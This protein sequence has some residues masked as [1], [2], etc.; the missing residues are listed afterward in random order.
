MK[1][2][3][4]MLCVV[5]TLIMCFSV[6][7]IT[8]LGI[9]VEAASTISDSEITAIVENY[10]SIV[11]SNRYWNAGYSTQELISQVNR[12]DYTTATTFAQCPKWNSSG[13]HVRAN[14]CTSNV[15]TGVS[16]GL[17]QCWGFGDYMEYVIFK[18]INGSDWTKEYS[19]DSNFKF[20]PGDLIHSTKNSSSQHIMV[21]YKV[22]GSHVY[23]IEANY[24]ARCKINTR[25]LVDPHSYVNA[26]SSYVMVPPSSLRIEGHSHSYTTN[27]E[28]AHPHKYYESCSCGDWHYTGTTN[29]SYTY[30]NESA[31]PHKEY[32]TCWCGQ[33]SYTGGVG[34]A[35]SCESCWDIQF[36]SSHST[37]SLSASSNE[38][39]T[40]SIGLSGSVYPSGGK[41]DYEFDDSVISVTQID[42]RTYTIKGVRAGKCDLVFTAYT[43]SALTEAI[44]SMTIPIE[45]TSIPY[46]IKYNG[47]GGTGVPSMQIKTYGN[48]KT[49]RTEIPTM[50]GFTFLGWST[51]SSAVTP[52]SR[53]DPGDVYTENKAITLYAVWKKVFYGDVNGD[54]KISIADVT[55]LNQMRYNE[56]EY[57]SLNKLKGDLDGDGEL[58]F[59]DVSILQN[60]N[61]RKVAFPVETMFRAFEICDNP[62]KIT[63]KTGE[64]IV[65]DGL[66][67]SVVYSNG[68][69]H[70]VD[71]GFS[72]SPEIASGSSTQKITVTLE[73]WSDYF[74]IKI[75]DS[76]A[77]TLSYHS[78]GG[79]GAPSNQTGSASYIISSTVPTKQG[80]TFLGW[81]KS[82]SATTV[83]YKPGSSINLT[84]NTTLYAVWKSAEAMDEGEGYEV[85]IDF[86]KQE[87]Y[88]TFT[89][90]VSGEYMFES[91]SSI[92]TKV[93]VYDSS[94]KQIGFNDDDGVGNNFLLYVNLTAGNKYYV[95][96]GAYGSG[97]GDL[98]FGV[99]CEEEEHEHS[100]SST[101]T[102]QPGCVSYGTREFKCSCGDTYTE[103]INPLGHN[104]KTEWTIDKKAT[105][106]E[107]GEKSHHCV[108]CDI[109]SAEET[110]K[111]TG[112]DFDGS[113]CKNCDYD[114][115]SDCSCNCH[116]GGIAGFFFKLILFFQK[117]FGSNKTCACGVAHY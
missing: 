77:Y 101:V 53:Y 100:Y 112:H 39:V 2:C 115:S 1:I 5:L 28:S 58:T 9:G 63:Y 12:G 31:H 4:K 16:S 97:T 48:D 41:F 38:S 13:S 44:T 35:R 11:G 87:L 56:I 109:G 10:I 8:E 45:V 76:V 50:E 32:K 84:A 94:W 81:S 57:S 26:S 15:F 117:I 78:N 85:S 42:A 49:L 80:Y 36:T 33:W 37:V 46:L 40:I 29:D 104:F 88:Y 96:V 61:L 95:K 64:T 116:K 99:A 71:E 108:R 21:V 74:Y 113:K 67:V 83:S 65:M 34:T 18:T 3:K 25:E 102:K 14:G 68:T 72:V 19:V 47:N 105:C 66:T 24:G 51:D 62:L 89:P 43:D 30:A 75:D 7:P 111:A 60:F 114:K 59:S 98:T 103:T 73:D 107:D 54:G 91:F 106:T 79:S 110:I 20:R 69:E 92:D 93:Y 86:A 23:I 90:D 17:S 55:T 27:Y 22:D 52:D 82:S 70:I 6:V